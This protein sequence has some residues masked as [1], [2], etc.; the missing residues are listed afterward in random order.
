MATTGKKKVDSAKTAAKAAAPAVEAERAKTPSGV[1]GS[2]NLAGGTAQG[3]GSTPEHSAVEPADP[4]P[5]KPKVDETAPPGAKLA[6]GGGS[7]VYGTQTP[8]IKGIPV[9]V[10]VNEGSVLDPSNLVEGVALAAPVVSGSPEM[11]SNA[12]AEYA[13][14]HQQWAEGDIKSIHSNQGEIQVD[15]VDSDGTVKTERHRA[16]N[17]LIK[18]F[19]ESFQDPKNAKKDSKA[20]F[21]KN[22]GKETL[23]ADPE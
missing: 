19:E 14:D 2:A 18:E 3:A 23:L 5:G 21:K 7:N 17:K 10:P 20:F 9:V 13:V 1:T 12:Q 22:F 16:D 11:I 15:V 8:L 6:G 4:A